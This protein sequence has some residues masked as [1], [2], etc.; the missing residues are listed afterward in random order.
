MSEISDGLSNTVMVVEY[1]SGRIAWMEPRDL[2][3]DEALHVFTSRDAEA[4]GVHSTEDLLF[5]YYWGR[6]VGLADGSVRFEGH[7][8]KR[9]YWS[10]LL[11]IDDGADPY[12]L[13]LV[14]PRAEFRRLE[15]DNC[16]RLALF[17]FLVVLPLPRV[18]LG[19]RPIQ[20][21]QG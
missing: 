19:R 14:D 12:E 3:L 18:W 5:R 7:G 10:A 21:A 20:S 13:E 16:L 4:A 6:Q 2:Q 15:L 9:D 17:L 11:T 1:Q 8:R